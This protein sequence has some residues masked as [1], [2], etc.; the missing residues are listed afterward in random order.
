MPCF[1]R[2]LRYPL[3]QVL[4]LTNKQYPSWFYGDLYIRVCRP[5]IVVIDAKIQRSHPGRSSGTASRIENSTLGSTHEGSLTCLSPTGN[6]RHSEY[7]EK[8]IFSEF[9][10]EGAIRLNAMELHTQRRNTA[11]HRGRLPESLTIQRPGRH[12]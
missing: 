7:S 6:A 5:T 1:R 9:A 2:W 4:H 11:L 10:G 12:P 8:H 3:R